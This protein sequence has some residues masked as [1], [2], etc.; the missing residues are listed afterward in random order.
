MRF[1]ELAQLY[2]ASRQLS[3]DY[4]RLII[5]TTIRHYID[6]RIVILGSVA[7]PSLE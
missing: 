2:I 1:A 3:K 6:P 4:S 5:T 7:L